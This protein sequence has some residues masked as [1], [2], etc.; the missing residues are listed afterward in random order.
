MMLAAPKT[1]PNSP[2]YRPR[3]RGGTTSPMIAWVP[4]N[5]PPP[6]SP[7]IARKAM[8][9][10]IVWL[11]PDRMDPTRKMMIAAWKNPLRPYWSP[12]LPH[13]GVEAVDESRYAVTTHERWVSSC[14]SATIVGRAV[15]TIV[16][17]SAA[18]RSPSSSALMI[19]RRRSGVNVST[20][21]GVVSVA[22]RVSVTGRRLLSA[23]SAAVAAA[24]QMHGATRLLVSSRLPG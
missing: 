23:C 20:G 14:R 5:R 10:V 18:R 9:S 17:S 24:R 19:R 22:R 21:R 8:S 11:S 4:T 2:W 16:W 15:E 3:S 7:W 13:N 12:S 6:P 1:A